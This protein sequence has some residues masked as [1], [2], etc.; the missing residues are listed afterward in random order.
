MRAMWVN[1]LNTCG[2]NPMVIKTRHSSYL[3]RR[4]ALGCVK[5]LYC[6]ATL[7][8]YS[9]AS[10]FPLGCI[11]RNLQQCPVIIPD[12]FVTS[13]LINNNMLYY[14][15]KSNTYLARYNFT[16]DTGLRFKRANLHRNQDWFLENVFSYRWLGQYY[17]SHDGYYIHLWSDLLTEHDFTR[18][19]PSLWLWHLYGS[20][21]Y[22]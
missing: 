9:I 11:L 5:S 22:W 3:F 1:L 6:T 4:S 12:A 17:I 15:V 21:I 8:N 18:P 13:T 7:Q 10:V 14:R 19:W 16:C 20:G 2:W